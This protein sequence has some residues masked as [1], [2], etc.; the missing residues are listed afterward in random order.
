MTFLKFL[1]L[2]ISLALATLGQKGGPY[3]D[4]FM[5]SGNTDII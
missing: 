4:V 5:L 2:L 3:E 1:F